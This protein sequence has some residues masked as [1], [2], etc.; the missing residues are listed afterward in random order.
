MEEDDVP[1]PGLLL[2]QKFLDPL[3]I[4]PYRLAQAIGVHVRRVSE[5]CKGNRPVTP[6][7]AA[8]LGLYFDCPPRWFLEAQAAYDAQHLEDLP[9]LKE[10]VRPLE[11]RREVVVTPRGTRMLRR[12]VGVPTVVMVPIGEVLSE[13][14]ARVG[15]EDFRKGTPKPEV[16]DHG[17][18]AFTVT[19]GETDA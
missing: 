11:N 4:S 3:G 6:D 12:S 14:L 9:R 2:K 13:R 8:R 10:I 5:L 18:G 7:T 16:I 19:G 1:H 15:E 17:N